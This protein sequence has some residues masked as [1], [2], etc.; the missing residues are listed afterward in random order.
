LT[1]AAERSPGEDAQRGPE[2]DAT[3]TVPGPLVSVI[4]PARNAAETIEAALRS[5]AAQKGV[6][7]EAIVVDD[8]ST[9]ATPEIVQRWLQ[10]DGRL[11]LVR[12]SPQGVSASRNAGLAVARGEWVCFLDADDWLAPGALARLLALS[13]RNPEAAVLVG[14]AARVSQDGR[15]W[16]Y[17]SRDLSDPFAVLA[18]HC[19]FPIHS[20]LARRSVVRSLGGFDENLCSSEDWDLWQRIA[21][22][23]LRFAQT[24]HRV[25]LYR[26][27]PGSL[28]RNLPTAAEQGLLVMRQ[29]HAPDPRLPPWA[30]HAAGARPDALAAHEL[31]YVLWSACRDIAAGGDGLATAAL[32]PGRIDVDFEPAAF[33]E[34]VASGMADMLACHPEEL[35]GC[36]PA[37][38]PKLHAVLD[39]V[40][41]EAERARL[42]A[43]AMGV[44]KAR[45][46]GGQPGDADLLQLEAPRPCLA[47]PDGA[48][49]AVLQL[50]REDSTLAAI[51]LPM[52]GAREG[53][54]LA[55]A[56][57]QQARRA[58]LTAALRA[59]QPWRKGAFWR[60]AAPPALD[61]RGMG[62]RTCAGKPA[63]L[64]ELLRR[65]VR[66]LAAVGLRRTLERELRPSMRPER[67][68]EHERELAA[69]VA[70]TARPTAACA[71]PQSPAAG[72]ADQ[73]DRAGSWDSFFGAE[74]PWNYGASAYERLKYEDTLE[75]VP[76]LP[77][78][79]ALE[80]ACAE[81]HFTNRL[82]GR[83]GALLATDI[84]ETALK[85]AAARCEGLRNV[86]FRQLDFMRGPLPGAYDL[87]VCSEVLYYAG[88]RLAS[89][90]RRLAAALR[91][92]GLLVMAHANQIADEPRA[93][94][95]DWGHAYGARTIGQAFAALPGLK[96]EREIHRELYRVQSFRKAQTDR[97]NPQPRLERRPLDVP[98]EPAV[99]R[100][101]VWGGGESRI[102]AFAR[103]AAIRLPILMYHRVAPAAS[104]PTLERYRVA[105]HTFAEQM[106]WLRARG[107]WGVSPEELAEALAANRPLPGRPVMITFDDGYADFAEHA[108][109]VLKKHDMRAV[110]FVVA[111]RTGGTADWD[112]AHGAPAPLLGWSQI[113]AMARD[114]LVV[115][116]HSF[117]HRPFTRLPVRD[118]YREILRSR[119]EIAQHTGREP[120]SVCY[121]YGAVDPVVER[122]AE[123]CGCRL[124]FAVSQAVA[125]L[126]DNPFRLPRLEISID[127]DLASFQ[128]KLGGVGS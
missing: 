103:E 94:G 16:P 81:G 7:W 18:A 100:N 39:Q 8:G 29:A 70:E 47:P 112:A 38:E 59:A 125:S 85:R 28:S 19:A 124:G 63:A 105:P 40:Y 126:A 108:W 23:G 101:V 117:S 82:A 68:S 95:F 60:A 71:P 120:I 32:L 31:Y 25:A 64:A 77:Q 121:P 17:P 10:R 54:D 56:I 26:A 13:R 52:L 15:L 93:T 75:L 128:R 55:E 3:S 41:P 109:P 99:A 123:E 50:R 111:G 2:V 76:H 44:V 98:L 53:A 27:R 118:V 46:N 65:R 74:D 66:H 127:D 91:P 104:G 106:A 86:A 11:R 92:G 90:A 9:D 43:L 78:G 6:S 102:A 4:I 49:F 88:A 67:P 33:G 79:S 58:P 69:L 119:A 57:A 51:G 36:W 61:L 5:L 48:D 83:V 72:R 116:S 97:S 96:L 34:L 14:E 84:S 113:S 1:L 12:R 24:R 30:P 35:A 73:P 80:L 110:M 20:A 21:R 42:K 107:Y 89:V 45:L 114:G 122:I 62:L 37:F 22:S 87:I 115:E